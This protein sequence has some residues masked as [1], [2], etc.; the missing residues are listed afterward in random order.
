MSAL[1]LPQSRRVLRALPQRGL[2]MIVAFFLLTGL[3]TLFPGLARSAMLLVAV[4]ILILG[5][6]MAV[7]WHLD[8]RHRS[9]L[10]SRSLKRF[11]SDRPDIVY[12]TR[13]FRTHSAPYAP[14]IVLRAVVFE[15]LAGQP[16]DRARAALSAP[17]PLAAFL[18]VDPSALRAWTEFQTTWQSFYDQQE[19]SILLFRR[20][21]ES[22]QR[23]ISVVIWEA[24]PL[25]GAFSERLFESLGL[26]A[27]REH[28]REEALESLV[29][30][31]HAS[32]DHLLSYTFLTFE[33]GHWYQR[34]LYR[35]VW[36]LES[37]AE[38]DV[39]LEEALG[40]VDRD[41]PQTFVHA[42]RRVLERLVA[43]STAVERNSPP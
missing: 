1:P 28:L 23:L 20:S 43:L 2:L 29:Q 40:G 30:S 7:L 8:H 19:E 18:S 27:R 15:V 16:A 5:C 34:P 14:Q 38:G 39:A 11:S 9:T 42:I 3:V 21:L 25:T 12:W 17:D 35:Q 31:T 4:E 41:L 22:H 13:E 10:S 26:F 33:R 37:F 6:G 36:P 32:R 24:S